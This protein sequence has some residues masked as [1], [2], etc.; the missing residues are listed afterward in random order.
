MILSLGGSPSCSSYTIFISGAKH[1]LCSI[2]LDGTDL[3]DQTDPIAAIHCS[4]LGFFAFIASLLCWQGKQAIKS[5]TGAI[6]HCK[7]NKI[8]APSNAWN[9][10]P[11]PNFRV[12]WFF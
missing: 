5:K 7:E 6:K 2:V 9:N 4:F 3:S 8:T 10:I 11:L 12:E 1:G